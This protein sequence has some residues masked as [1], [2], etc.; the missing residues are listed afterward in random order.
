M[1]L[2]NHRNKVRET[3]EVM[4]ISKERVYHILTEELGM[5]KLTTRVIAFVDTYFAEQDANYYLND[6]NGWRHRSEKCINLKGD[7]VEK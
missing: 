1:I 5:R 7:Y 4:S 2:D 6:L 3:A